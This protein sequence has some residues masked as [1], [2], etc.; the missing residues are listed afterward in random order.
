MN[1]PVQFLQVLTVSWFTNKP[2]QEAD[3]NI[4]SESRQ[5]AHFSL[6]VH[7][8]PRVEVGIFNGKGLIFNIV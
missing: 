7:R 1:K 8:R 3:T 2:D 4:V 6:W 5:S